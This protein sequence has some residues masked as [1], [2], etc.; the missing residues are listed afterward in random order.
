[1]VY[2]K[3]RLMGV[4][5]ERIYDFEA[6]SQVVAGRMS[7]KRFRHTEQVVA[8]AAKMAVLHGADPEKARIA[9]LFHDCCK[10]EEAPGNNLTHAGKAA[11]LM[12][13]EFGI[14]D[15]DILNAVRYHTTGRAHMSKLELIVFL[16]D[17]LEPSRKYAGI[18]ALR[19]LALKDLYRGAMTVLR[20]LKLYLERNGFKMDRD[21][22]EAIDWLGGLTTRGRVS[23]A[24]GTAKRA[25]DQTAQPTDAKSVQNKREGKN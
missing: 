9:A 8:L 4:M 24:I 7:P 20:E 18:D 12:Q 14:E 10:D 23:P 25:V 2:T 21:G 11:D 15:A 3:C 16:A 19:A 1:M 17:T 22:L 6:L 13:S 5:A